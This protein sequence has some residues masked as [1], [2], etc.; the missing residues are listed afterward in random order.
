[1]CAGF[2]G[3]LIFKPTSTLEIISRIGSFKSAWSFIFGTITHIHLC[4][5]TNALT[6]IARLLDT[7]HMAFVIIHLWH[8]LI[9]SFGNYHA[10]MIVTWC[11]PCHKVANRS[12]ESKAA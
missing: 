5:M 9:D 10:L 7:I 8:Y 2:S 4:D 12:D 11:V 1:M 3:S 6:K